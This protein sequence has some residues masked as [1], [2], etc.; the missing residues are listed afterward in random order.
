MVTLDSVMRSSR[1]VWTKILAVR[2][3]ALDLSDGTLIYIHFISLMIEYCEFVDERKDSIKAA[4]YGQTP[5]LKESLQVCVGPAKDPSPEMKK[6]IWH[7][8]PA[9]TPRNARSRSHRFEFS[10]Q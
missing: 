7:S 3:S 4:S 5:D 10:A 1:R 9:G 6:P 8:K 2:A